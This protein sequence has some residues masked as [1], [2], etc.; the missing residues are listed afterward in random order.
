MLDQLEGALL[1]HKGEMEQVIVHD[2]EQ[3]FQ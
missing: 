3:F 2:G 1:L